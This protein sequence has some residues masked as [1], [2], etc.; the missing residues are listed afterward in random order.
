VRIE[1][2]VRHR[3]AARLGQVSGRPEWPVEHDDDAAALDDNAGYAEP[4]SDVEEKPAPRAAP[5]PDLHP[6][7]V[8]VDL[9][10]EDP[11]FDELD[12]AY[13]PPYRRAVGE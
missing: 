7:A 4:A 6:R 10:D 9:D 8:A 2:E 1:E 11:A 3:R 5:R 13:E 12:P